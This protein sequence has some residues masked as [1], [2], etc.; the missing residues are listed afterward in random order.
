[1]LDLGRKL[2]EHINAGDLLQ[3]DQR[4]DLVNAASLVGSKV[5][6]STVTLGVVDSLGDMSRDKHLAFEA[7]QVF[8]LEDRAC[9]HIELA[10]LRE[11]AHGSLDT[12]PQIA[13]IGW[14]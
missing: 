11:V 7:R 6:R 10:P 5:S 13:I 9:H 3:L 14:V 12:L 2:G 4:D 8:T 1:M